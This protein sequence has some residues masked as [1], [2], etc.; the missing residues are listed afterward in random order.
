MTDKTN[1][2]NALPPLYSTGEVAKMLGRSINGTLRIGETDPLFPM[3]L[4]V[5]YRSYFVKSEIDAYISRIM[6]REDA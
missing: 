5:G 6:A 2:T 1:K 3:A 4:K